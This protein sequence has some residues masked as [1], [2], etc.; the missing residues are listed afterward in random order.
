MAASYGKYRVIDKIGEGSFGVVYLAED[1]LL[2][3]RVALKVSFP[4]T[5]HRAALLK[6]AGLLRHMHHDHVV[7][8]FDVNVDGDALYIAMEYLPGGSLKDVLKKRGVLDADVAITIITDV[9]AAIAYAHHR[10]VLHRDVKPANIL[11]DAEGRAKLTDF[12]VARMLETTV[13]STRI[14]TVPYMAPEQLEGKAT[15]QS[16]LYAA[17]VVLYEMTT[18]ARAF[19]GESE[20]PIMKKIERGVFTPPRA[21]NP[22]IPPWVEGVILKAMA[23]DATA[24]FRSARE[25][26]AALGEE[27][28]P[29]KAEK[30]K[31]GKREPVGPLSTRKGEN[32]GL[33]AEPPSIQPGAEKERTR[34]PK[35]RKPPAWLWVTFAAALT[36]LAIIVICSYALIHL[37]NARMNGRIAAPAA[38]AAPTVE[39]AVT[40]ADVKQ[41]RELQR[42]LEVIVTRAGRIQPILEKAGLEVDA[43]TAGVVRD[44]A[45]HDLTTVNA[46]ITRE[47]SGETDQKDLADIGGRAKTAEATLKGLEAKAAERLKPPPAG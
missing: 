10:N 26:A 29:P 4:A 36:T 13:A 21:V 17:G 23:V 3:E 12:G 38:T 9:L 2:G 7:L 8:V 30:I 24:R 34:P 11:F 25:M 40:P 28:P 39:T 31:A 1:T 20:Y 37:L 5:E 19:D 45:N 47:G 16:D 18:G 41:A 33:R 27:F 42:R 32:I 15:F 44:K 35:G 22:A 46:I 14:G 6:E 43:A